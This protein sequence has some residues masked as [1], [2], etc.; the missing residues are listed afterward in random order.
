MSD[1]AN[2]LQRLLRDPHNEEMLKEASSHLRARPLEFA[3][4]AQTVL[5]SKPQ[6]FAAAAQK[7]WS[8]CIGNQTCTPASILHP[9]SCEDLVNAVTQ[10]ANAGQTVRAVGSGHSFSDV[11]ITTG[12][13][14]DPHGMNQVLT[15]DVS[16]L[17]DPSAAS[18]LF[19][20]QSGISIHNLNLALDKAGLAL[21]NMGAY[22]AQTLAG[23]MSTSTHGTGAELGPFPSAVASLVLV[24]QDGTLY[25]LE[26]SNG[27]TDPAKFAARYPNIVLKQD[28]AWFQS[29]VVAMGCMGLIYSYTLRVMPAYYLLE[30]R[31]ETTWEELKPQLKA[32]PGQLPGCITAHRHYEIDVN[33]YAVNGK[34]SCIVT[35]RDI[36]PGPAS[37][38]RGVSNWVAG[39]MASIPGVQD[40]LVDLLNA[41]PGLIPHALDMG[42]SSLKDSNYIDKS[43]KVLNLGA[44]NNA[45][46]YALELSFDA[47][48]FVDSIDQ[49]LELYANYAKAQHYYQTGP[50][51]IR[52]VAPAQAYLSPQYG[53]T[54]CMA[55][56]DML[57][58]TKNGEALLD[59]I[60][61][62]MCAEPG[63]R[64]H[65]GLEL[66]VLQGAQLPQMYSQ[67]PQWKSVYQQLN[68][69][70]LFDNS[71]TTRM[72]ISMRPATAAET[73]QK[74]A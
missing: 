2:L 3:Q 68:S 40:L 41:V 34:H 39:I 70:G 23:A 17:K 12:V 28:D 46:A 9:S 52:F 57:T 53:R 74:S 22:D 5:P 73:A 42:L 37:G 7:S 51:G 4:A 8:N 63:V 36:V 30:N 24:A 44:V 27:I 26:P 35:T 45:S 20:V 55:E 49:L 10:A 60:Q 48:S 32:E 43:Y 29:N 67:F 64:V 59:A 58:H 11:A 72:N 47:G 38:T 61:K 66:D 1:I 71:F 18:G 54:T 13:L 15:V 65:W 56:L 62:V 16:V 69:K 31:V 14:L 33:P 19:S 21:I 6:P 25:Q 50:V